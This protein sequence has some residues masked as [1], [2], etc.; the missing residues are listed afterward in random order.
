MIHRE[1]VERYP[2]TLVELAA[3]IGDL[4]Y[5]T[6]AAFL[7]ALAAKLD[8]DGAADVRRGRHGLAAALRDA[9]V[10]VAEAAADVERAWSICAP[11]MEA[12]A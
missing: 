7:R 9:G 1:D 11:H 12:D 3:D 6:L 8:A 5:D 4:R 10:S 2:G